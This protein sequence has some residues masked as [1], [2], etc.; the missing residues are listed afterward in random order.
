MRSGHE[1]RSVI[2]WCLSSLK[3]SNW[4]LTND[5]GRWGKLKYL[6]KW[7]LVRSACLQ[8][9]C[10]LHSFCCK[11]KMNL[12]THYP[13]WPYFRKSCRSQPKPLGSLTLLLE[14]VH[15]SWNSTVIYILL[16][17]KFLQFD[18]LRAVVFL[19]NLKYLHVKITNLFRVVV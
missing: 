17:E 18:W 16:H 14:V 13:N 11:W 3:N 12:A 5:R 1:I 7:K 15:F 10:F 9:L 4:K 6:R 8:S 2:E 19:L